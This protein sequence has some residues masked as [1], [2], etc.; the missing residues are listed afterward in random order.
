MTVQLGKTEEQM[1][2]QFAPLAALVA[3]FD[4]QNVFEPL[5]SMASAAEKGDN[6][7]GNKLYQ[8]LISIMCG[9]T[10]ISEVNTKLRPERIFAQ[11]NRI[12]AF[13]EQS[14]L[15]LALNGLSQMNI[16]QL[17]PAVR[18][19]SNRCSHTKQHDWRGLLMF[20]FDLSGLPCRKG[21]EGAQK[22]YFAGKKTASG[23]NWLGLALS[24]TRKRYGPTSF[25]ATI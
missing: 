18:Q 13:A 22:G 9:C 17:R 15:A 21:A 5:R 8:V 20:D 14:T 6:G 24:V 23:D 16:A 4:E 3:Y 7:L 2:T 1:N 11:V 25:R 10:Y 12:D 19:I